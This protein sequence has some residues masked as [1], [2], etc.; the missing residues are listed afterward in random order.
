M[1]KLVLGITVF[2]LCL[3]GV[4]GAITFAEDGEPKAA[5]STLK[6]LFSRLENEGKLKSCYSSEKCFQE[7]L[8]EEQL[9]ELFSHY[10]IIDQE[11]KSSDVRND[12]LLGLI[13]GSSVANPGIGTGWIENQQFLG[14]N[15]DKWYWELGACS[16]NRRVFVDALTM[17]PSPVHKYVYCSPEHELS[18]DEYK[19]MP[20]WK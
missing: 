12:A 5:S 14:L 13:K 16:T 7:D 15:S 11:A 8:T 17:V 18:L 19:K 20:H 9:H 6:D 3:S 4:I 2:G 10:K 1:N